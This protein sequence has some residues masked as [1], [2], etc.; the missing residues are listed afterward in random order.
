MRLLCFILFCVLHSVLFA[1]RAEIDSLKRR[2]RSDG[3]D[4]IRVN[5]LNELAWQFLDYSV[6]SSE[7][8][9]NEALRVAKKIGYT[10]GIADAKNTKGIIRRLQNRSEEA[11]KLYEEVVKLRIDSHREDKLTGAYSNLGSVY[12]ES[13]DYAQALKNYQR[14]FD[15]ALRFKQEE[16]QLILLNNIGVAYKSS[17]LYEQALESFRKGLR[18]NRKIRNDQQEAQL[19]LN[20]ATIYDL[21]NMHTESVRYYLHAYEFFKKE[22]NLRLLSTVVYD[23]TIATR[24]KGD[25]TAAKRYLKEMEKLAAQLNEDD[26]TC[27]FHQSRTNLLMVTGHC[28]DALAE[29]NK[30]LKYADSTADPGQYA[31][32]LLVKADVYQCQ[33]LYAPALDLAEKGLAIMKRLDDPHE[34]AGAYSGLYEINKAAGNYERALYYSEKE[35]EVRAQIA[36]DEVSNQIATLN[37][38]NELD[39]KEQQIAL[40][41]KEKQQVKAENER[42]R[43]QMAAILIIALLVLVLLMFSY[44]AY[45]LKQKANVQLSRQK[46]EIET[47]KALVEEKQSEILDSIHY[48]RRIQQ[49]LLAQE[50]QLRE[51]LPDHFV[52]FRPKD[53][54]SGDFYWSTQRG[55]R[56][57]LAVCDSTGHGVPGAFMSLLNSSFLNE[58]INDRG[59]TEPNAIF[60]YVRKRLVESISQEG[61]QDGMDGVL[62]CID[63]S[64]GTFTYA[65]AHSKPL[66]IRDGQALELPCDKMPVGKGERSESF[67]LFSIDAREGDFLYLFSDGFADQFGGPKGKKF[68]YKPLYDALCGLTAYPMEQQ[69]SQLEQLFEAWKGELEQVDDVTVTGIRI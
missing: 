4:T 36:I 2:L 9:T 3:Q 59:I 66:L 15:N 64:N 40:A 11:L 42:R 58:A 6:D 32:L 55:E 69:R 45:R 25:F 52:L 57:Y 12:Y 17:G 14:A 37:A 19:Y 31:K 29:V 61:A 48:A 20:I 26:Y 33:R 24:E 54:V 46:Q 35:K 50:R 49:T 41:N 23:L 51:A 47:Q 34:L 8:Y 13:R 63:R 21:R 67:R 65:A 62:L 38:L 1:Q 22:N 16:N 60:D 56:F 43:V 18:M 27:L 5:D 39:Q 68:K 44:R 53:I 7:R 10:N 28:S 30:A